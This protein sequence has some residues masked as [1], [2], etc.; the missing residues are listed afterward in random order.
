M[1]WATASLAALERSSRGRITTW[2]RTPTRPF[3]RRHAVTLPFPF[4]IASAPLPKFVIHG[5]TPW[6]EL[7]KRKGALASI[8]LECRFSI[9]VPIRACGRGCRNFKIGGTRVLPAFGLEIVD[10]DVLAASDLLD[11][12]ADVLAILDR[13]V[14]FAEI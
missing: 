7:R 1:L 11:E 2:L 12:A 3:S 13:G 6:H 8:W 5:S 10:V 9:E 14:A 4:F